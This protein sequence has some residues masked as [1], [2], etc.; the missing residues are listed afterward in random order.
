MTLQQ[1]NAI[2]AT[3]TTEPSK[4]PSISV[5]YVL[6]TDDELASTLS[7]HQV[8]GTW[9]Q[10]TREEAT[11]DAIEMYNRLRSMGGLQ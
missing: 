4:W 8:I 6:T 5:R 3:V 9:E 10:Q 1:M 11:A 7:V 2:G